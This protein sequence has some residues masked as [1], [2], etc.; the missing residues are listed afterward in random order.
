MASIEA[1]GARE[2]LDSRGNPTVEVEVA[3]DDGT[4]R[5]RGGA[6]PAPRPARSRRSSCATA[7]PTRY[8]GKGVEKA[9]VGRARR[10]RPRADRLRRRPSSGW[11]T[12]RCSTS[13]ARRTSRGW[14]P[15]RSSAS[16]S[17]WPRPPRSRPSLPL[18]RYVGGPNAHVLPVPMMNILNGGAHADTNVD[19]QEFM[20]A[21]IGA[22]TFREALRWGAEVYHALK[23]VLKEQGPVHRPRRRG[24]LRPRPARATA[25]ALDLIAEAIEKAGYTLGTRHRAGARR[26]RDR[27]LHRRRATPSR[28]RPAR[29][30]EMT[31]YYAEP[32]RRLPARV[33]RGP[34]GR[35]RLGRLD[36][37]HRRARRPGPDRRRRP[38]RHQPGAAASAASTRAPPTRCWSR[39]TRS[40]R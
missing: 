29:P 7:T 12:R 24:R 33:D 34:A 21:P 16:R 32:G 1:V 6:R 27:V 28:A 15:T 17:R 10:D 2:I 31:G 26:R 38:V 20:I 3:L 30:S 11:S 25:A 14:A 35:G 23:S 36:G 39:S 5:P 37:A 8:G 19:V 4:A 9:V 40:A 13:T 18:F 22:P